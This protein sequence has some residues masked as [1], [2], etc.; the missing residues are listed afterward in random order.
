MIIKEFRENNYLNDKIFSEAFIID[1][2]RLKKTGPLLIKNKLLNKGVNAEIIDSKITDLYNE[3]NQVKNCKLLAEK[4]LNTLNKNLS[5]AEK[6]SKLSNYLRQ[7]GYH[8]EIIKN[9]IEPFFTGENDE[10]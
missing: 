8:W 10:E 5:T 4:K 1:E 2:I 6:K 7:K 3:S 9:E